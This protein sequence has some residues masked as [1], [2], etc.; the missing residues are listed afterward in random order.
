MLASVTKDMTSG[1]P[2]QVPIGGH[3]RAPE[4]AVAPRKSAAEH[5]QLVQDVR[6]NRLTIEVDR[7][8][9]KKLYTSVPMDTMEQTIGEV[10]Y[11]EKGIVCCAVF[12]SP[13]L[14]VVGIALSAFG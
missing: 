3:A 5:E 4:H 1:I 7:V 2:R 14:L 11:F 10:P 8:F 9:A 13:V 12:A 6:T